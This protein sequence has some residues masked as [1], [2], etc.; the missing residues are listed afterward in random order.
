MSVWTPWTPKSKKQQQQVSAWSQ[1]KSQAIGAYQQ[2][3]PAAASQALAAAAP[4]KKKSGGI[5]GGL[6]DAIGEGAGNLVSIGSDIRD[7]GSDIVHARPREA[8]GDTG[9]TLSSLVSGAND[10]LGLAKKHIGE[11]I[12]G[13]VADALV[14]D[15]GHFNPFDPRRILNAEVEA[16][17]LAR[18]AKGLFQRENPYDYSTGRAATAHFQESDAPIGVKV[19]A[20]AFMDPLTYAG[21]GLVAKLGPLRHVVGQPLGAGVG[22]ALGSGAAAQGADQIDLP[23][24]AQH[25]APLVGAFVGGATGGH[26]EQVRAAAERSRAALSEGGALGG[27]TGSA[28]A[29]F[30][31]GDVFSRGRGIEEPDLSG[32]AGAVPSAAPPSTGSPGGFSLR[33]LDPTAL[34]SKGYGQL[35]FVRGKSGIGG[36]PDWM[37]DAPDAYDGSSLINLKAVTSDP[38]LPTSA[39]VSNAVWNALAKVGGDKFSMKL[40]DPRV[41]QIRMMHDMNAQAIPAIAD[42]EAAIHTAPVR[43]LPTDAA[44][45]ALTPDG[46]PI[47]YINAA[48]R[49]ELFKGERIKA[50]WQDIAENPARYPGA[51]TPE[52]MATFK[53]MSD[54]MGAIADTSRAMGIKIEGAVQPGEGGVYLS[55]I[56][57]KPALRE[58]GPVSQVGKRYE[59]GKAG[60]T[61]ERKYKSGAAA[62]A[63]GQVVPGP[64]EAFKLYVQ[65]NLE[66]QNGTHAGNLLKQVTL[67]DGRTIG[68]SAVTQATK[69]ELGTLRTELR[70]QSRDLRQLKGAKAIADRDVRLGNAWINQAVTR[71]QELVAKAQDAN[72]AL[73]VR[74]SSAVEALQLGKQ[75]LADALSAAADLERK[76][77]GLARETEASRVAL[78]KVLDEGTQLSARLNAVEDHAAEAL[79]NVAHGEA[80]GYVNGMAVEAQKAVDYAKQVRETAATEAATIQKRLEALPYSDVTAR[81]QDALNAA[82][83][84][85]ARFGATLSDARR[86][87]IDIE[88]AAAAEPAAAER[89]RAAMLQG[90]N[91]E[92][93]R[94]WR[95]RASQVLRAVDRSS[96]LG[97]RI[98][99]LSTQMEPGVQRTKELRAQVQEVRKLAHER[100]QQFTGEIPLDS[101]RGIKVPREMVNAWTKTMASPPGTGAQVFDLVNNSFRMLGATADASR[102]MTVGLLG[103]ADNPLIGGRAAVAGV[104]TAM[105]ENHM[106]NQL[107]ATNAKAVAEGLPPLTEAIG[108]DGL[109]L[110]ESEYSLKDA[111]PG[112]FQERFSNLPVIK[113]ADALYS[114]PGNI[115]RVERYYA[116][117]RRLKGEGKDWTSPQARESAANAANLIG[118]RARNGV[119]SPIIGTDAANRLAFAGR[120]TQSQ[121]EVVANA[122]LSGGIEGYE[123]RKALLRLAT[124]VAGATFA[125][126]YALGNDTVLDSGDPNFLAIRFAGTDYKLG[127]AYQ[128]LLAGVWKAAHEA[129]DSFVAKDPRGVLNAPADILRSKAGPIAGAAYD[130]TLGHG[131]NPIGDPAIGTSLIPIPYGIRDAATQ[132]LRTDFSD[133]TAIGALALAGTAA[134]TGV[135]ANPL[136]PTEELNQAVGDMFKGKEYAELSPAEQNQVRQAHPDLWQ[137][138]VDAGSAASRQYYSRKDELVAEQK[139]SDAAAQSGSLTKSAWL[140]QY[141]DRQAKLAEAGRTIFGDKGIKQNPKT[142][143]DYYGNFILM[144]RNPDGSVDWDRVN[145]AVATLPQAMQDT[146][147]ETHSLGSTPMV[148]A[149][150]QA[151]ALRGQMLDLAKYSGYTSDQAREIDN[152]IATINAQLKPGASTGQKLA[153][154]RTMGVDDAKV[155]K[156]VKASLFKYIQRVPATSSKSRNAFAKKN[157]AIEQ[158]FGKG[159]FTPLDVQ[160]LGRTA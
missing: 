38:A 52:Q 84:A 150:K 152:V 21:P 139:A 44:G 136:T 29:D 48:G 79:G 153:V 41:R 137:S 42:A 36:L 64:A 144:A 74:Q 155:L 14:D 93:T 154:L 23:P 140:S 66:Q 125:I 1:I 70:P 18:I 141:H 123:A 50:A 4:P 58:E 160:T 24:W 49:P 27:E 120:F 40:E 91:D 65:K 75:Q 105:D 89:A 88:A 62:I 63:D 43:D 110:A 20:G 149:Y 138:K 112:S 118:G 39:K 57:T 126:N 90:R 108:K 3:G 28:R 51:L 128:S 53:A 146:I 81:H 95:Q 68:A 59:D 61:I 6:A 56:G 25:L 33:S 145:A 73:V 12:G 69:D 109:M 86:A 5:F 100:G 46:A 83:D 92:L 115:E 143:Q 131:K 130:L 99:Q 45:R 97:Q 114:A 10:T 87:R 117:L 72:Q 135:R 82:A 96:E 124:G 76:T 77:G 116:Q 22:A 85:H 71:G 9:G 11:P 134:L 102:M 17:P 32:G 158:F 132:A 15:S 111:K 122:A 98:E 157:P 2:G 80:G 30:G 26:P 148:R 16:N 19:G 34:I 37:I 121:L 127:G 35:P 129:G 119:L 107:R 13:P 159:D 104:R 67:E 103:N 54:R 78:K 7:V 147:E 133:P 151:V 55:R 8:W 60:S 101:M 142:A 47:D 94:V 106:W 113:Q 156:G 31:L